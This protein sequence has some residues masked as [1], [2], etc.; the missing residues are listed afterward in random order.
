META[1]ARMM[2]DDSLRIVPVMLDE[3]ALPALLQ[4]FRRL[5]YWEHEDIALIAIQLM[6]L[7]SQ[8]EWLQAVQETLDEAAIEVAFFY[9]YGAVVCCPSCGASVD[10]L[11][12]W[13][14]VDP[15]RDDTYAGVECTECGFN[16]GG[17]VM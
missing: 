2:E 14:Q 16:D 10:K 15:R 6:G 1:F 13:S 12:G 4:P 11:K 8:R 9:G 3:I 5:D 17:E 7:E